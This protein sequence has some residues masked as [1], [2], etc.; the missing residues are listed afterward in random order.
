MAKPTLIIMAAG[1][2]SRYGGLKQID[3][4]GPSQEKILDYSVYDAIKAGF[5]RVVFVIKEEMQTLFR[6]HVGDKISAAIPVDYVYQRLEELPEG[7]LPLADRKKPWGTAHAVYC[8]R[9]VVREPFAVI[10]ADDFYG[11]DA[12]AQVAGFFKKT[13]QGTKHNAC[14]VGY[15]VENTLTEHGS[16]TRGVCVIS[17]EGYLKGIA[18]RLRIEK[19]NGEILDIDDDG[20]KVL[21]PGT[22]VSMNFWGFAPSVMQEFES[23]L[24]RFFI[25]NRDNIKTAEFYL[26]VFVNEIVEDGKSDVKVL[27]TSAKWFGV[28]YREDKAAVQKAIR[29]LVKSGEYP[30]KLWRD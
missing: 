25:K 10:N 16:V 17:N 29:E 8:C 4:V 6:E 22:V 12:F 13:Q 21:A 26:P 28:T 9:E 11:A 2:G 7:S 30:Q 5:G 1:M 15:N 23:Y 3:P 19:K 24:K 27:E 20:A 14:M 18:E